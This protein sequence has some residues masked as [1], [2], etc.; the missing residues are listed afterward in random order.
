[1]LA[2]DKAFLNAELTTDL[3]RLRE[4]E[5]NFH[6]WHYNQLGI[7]ASVLI[8]LAL[9]FVTSE[10]VQTM[11]VGLNVTD[12]E[13]VSRDIV[14]FR[15]DATSIRAAEAGNGQV[16]S[17]SHTGR[18]AAGAMWE[19]G[20]QGEPLARGVALAEL[21]TRV[22]GG[23][24]DGELEGWEC[25][26]AG[27]EALQ[28]C[29]SFFSVVA[30][31][32]FTQVCISTL[33]LSVLGPRL[34]LHGPPGSMHRSVEML[35]SQRRHTTALMAAGLTVFYAAAGIHPW[36]YH[37]YRVALP[38][39]IMMCVAFLLTAIS[40]RALYLSFRLPKG[41]R[42]VAG[43]YH[44]DS[45]ARGSMDEPHTPGRVIQT[46]QQRM[47]PH[48]AEVRKSAMPPKHKLAA[49]HV[50]AIV[51]KSD[52]LLGALDRALATWLRLPDSSSP[53]HELQQQQQPPAVTH[54][55]SSEVMV[56]VVRRPTSLAETQ[57]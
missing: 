20:R 57:P 44:T 5:L 36:I 13:G 53:H 25:D 31:S 50:P 9:T 17:L 15:S 52:G 21:A 42:K 48:S 35:S 24:G 43:Y 1:M 32:C 33:M 49:S 19:G 16:G 14:S 2:A 6:V 45:F 29:F 56:R 7:A 51:P 39:T 38:S 30:F 54:M 26:S 12:P 47:V 27:T 3:V 34:A 22:G 55:R 37:D 8:G 23:L 28:I 11:C 10:R 18:I 4:K 40:A 46:I 41:L